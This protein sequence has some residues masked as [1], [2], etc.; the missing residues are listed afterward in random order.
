MRRTKISGD[1][2]NSFHMTHNNY[3]QHSTVP[4]WTTDDKTN[5]FHCVVLVEGHGEEL[6]RVIA[7]L[8]KHFPAGAEESAE[9]TARHRVWFG[10]EINAFQKTPVRGNICTAY[11]FRSDGST[12]PMPIPSC[13]A[14]IKGL[15]DEY[16]KKLVIGYAG[17]DTQTNPYAIALATSSDSSKSLLG[18]LGAD[19]YVH[20]EIMKHLF[21]ADNLDAWLKD[22]ATGRQIGELGWVEKNGDIVAGF[23][24]DRA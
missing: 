1:G 12:P 15:M 5:S 14:L 6:S 3:I 13:L 17:I 20:F 24:T 10:K 8:R 18:L 7:A 2:G 22:L 9:E 11:R 4:A 16:K 19:R 23:V 21:Y